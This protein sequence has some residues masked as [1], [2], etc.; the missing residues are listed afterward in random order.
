M[1]ITYKL[2]EDDYDELKFKC[3]HISDRFNSKADDLRRMFARL[4]MYWVKVSLNGVDLGEACIDPD[5]ENEL[6]FDV[7]KNWLKI[8]LSVRLRD[9]ITGWFICQPEYKKQVSN[10]RKVL[11]KIN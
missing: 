4:D 5:K 3:R 11:A 9:L 1:K 6:C 10:M 7:N 2:E 8:N